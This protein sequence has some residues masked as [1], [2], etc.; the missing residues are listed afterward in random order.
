MLEPVYRSL[1]RIAIVI[2]KAPKHGHIVHVSFIP[3]QNKYCYL[4]IYRTK[5]IPNSY[6]EWPLRTLFS[7]MVTTAS[8]WMKTY[9]IKIAS[10]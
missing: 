5:T 2:N 8:K 6:W 1:L 10:Q 3:A 9:H 7:S 4:T